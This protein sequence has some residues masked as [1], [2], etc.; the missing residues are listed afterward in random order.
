MKSSNELERRCFEKGLR[1][2]RVA[3]DAFGEIAM[4]GAKQLVTMTEKANKRA[5]EAHE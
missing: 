3:S 5:S 4:D 2:P 1:E